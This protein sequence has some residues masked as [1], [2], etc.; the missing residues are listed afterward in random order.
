ME[1]LFAGLLL[2]TLCVALYAVIHKGSRMT[3]V[4]RLLG[5]AWVANLFAPLIVALMSFG[6]CFIVKFVFIAAA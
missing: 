2:L 6:C 4:P 3:P 5:D 1:T